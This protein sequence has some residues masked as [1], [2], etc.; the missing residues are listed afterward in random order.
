MRDLPVRME[1][2]LSALGPETLMT[3]IP[4]GILPEDRAKIVL[5]FSIFSKKKPMYK[6]EVYT[7][8]YY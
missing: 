8:K 2:Q 7:I 4:E 5:F 1:I 6:K 3:P